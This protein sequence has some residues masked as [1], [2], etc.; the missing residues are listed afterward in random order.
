MLGATRTAAQKREDFRALLAGSDTVQFPGAINPINAQLI[1]QAGFEGVRVRTVRG[2][3]R[4]ILHIVVGRRPRTDE[5][6]R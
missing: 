3:Q 4:G 6:G 2:W 1:E 5:V